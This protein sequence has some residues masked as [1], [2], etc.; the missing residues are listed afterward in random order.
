MNLDYGDLKTVLLSLITGVVGYFLSVAIHRS[1]SNRSIKSMKR[2]IEENEAYKTNLNNLAKSDRALLIRG[3][4]GVFAV[5]CLMN[6][7]FGFQL[8]LVKLH[9]GG[10]MNITEIAIVFLWLLGGLASIGLV[11]LMRD[12]RQYP[13]SIEKLENRITKLKNKLLSRANK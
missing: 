9:E 5:L 13:E 1:W 3:F 11:K 7:L 10:P 2:R 6:T 4:E 8:M 12:V